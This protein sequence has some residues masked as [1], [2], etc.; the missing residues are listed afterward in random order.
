MHFFKIYVKLMFNKI[1]INYIQ[2]KFDYMTLV[3]M[4]IASGSSSYIY[5]SK[6]AN[7]RENFA[8]FFSSQ[9]AF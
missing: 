7:Q 5:F 8:T 4:F 1:L 2:L 6:C 3:E 9:D